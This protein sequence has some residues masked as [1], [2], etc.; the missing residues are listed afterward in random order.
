MRGC[1]R[2]TKLPALQSCQRIVLSFG[3]AD[4]NQRMFGDA[5]LGWLYS[6][7]LAGLLAVLRRP[8]R[9]AMSFAFVP[10]G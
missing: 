3:A 2:M 8:W 6:L 10:F 9:I 7:G 4:L 1:F 5:P